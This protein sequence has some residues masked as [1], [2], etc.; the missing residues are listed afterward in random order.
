MLDNPLDLFGI[1]I[2]FTFTVLVLSY[3]LGDNMLFR[4][5]IHIFIGAAAGYAA[6][7]ALKD[8]LIFRLSNMTDTQMV[9][10]LFWIGLL[11]LKLFGSSPRISRLGNLASAMMVGVGAAVAIGGAIQGTLVP[12]ISAAGDFFNTA[13][14][15]NPIQAL[16]WG[17]FALV[18]TITS[19][20]HFHFSAK[21]VPNQIPKRARWIEI[22]SMIGKVF[23]AS[24]FGVIFA[25]IY[26]AAL[27]A[28][29][30]RFD[31]I[32]YMIELVTR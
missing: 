6:A 14:Y 15:D 8:V 21:A 29:I 13:G 30:E 12:Q 31:F 5:A 27:L 18:G 3:A 11:G 28:L 2:S 19:L 20:A 16:I 9:V 25:G 7:V 32:A 17:S 23:I 4:L 1:L 10:A 24:A 26:S 22:F